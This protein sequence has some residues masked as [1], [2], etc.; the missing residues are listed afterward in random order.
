MIAIMGWG[1]VID[2]LIYFFNPVRARESL[3]I[4]EKPFLTKANKIRNSVC[5]LM[6][7]VVCNLLLTYS[8]LSSTSFDSLLCDPIVASVFHLI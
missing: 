8:Y 1:Q 4:S 5:A 6:I 3:T 7:N 2:I